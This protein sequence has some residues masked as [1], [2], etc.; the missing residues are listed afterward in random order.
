MGK[1]EERASSQAHIARKSGGAERPL[2][3]IP[4]Q[5]FMPRWMSFPTNF[6]LH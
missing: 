4:I 3:I 6:D 2:Q 5:A 1:S